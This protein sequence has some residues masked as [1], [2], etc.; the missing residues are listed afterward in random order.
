MD[1]Y[2]VKRAHKNLYSSSAGD[3][4]EVDVPEFRYLAVEGS[5]DPN[6]SRA[7]AEAVEALYSVSYTIKFAS[8]KELGR[9]AVVG[10]LEGLWWAD[11]M[12]T[13]VSRDK[14]AW[15]WTMLINQPPWVTDEMVDSAKAVVAKKKALAS[16]PLLHSMTWT[17]GRCVQILHI[18]AYDDEGPTL[19]SLHHRVLPERGLTYNG[20]HHEIY[21]S[22]PRRTAPGSLKTILRQPVTVA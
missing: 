10:P 19:E 16:L 15:K 20:R 13:F 9:D 14:R 22:D 18:G 11:D 8:K 12:S 5:G 6:S 3:F 7:Y 17:E 2:D 1:K 4:T 21:L